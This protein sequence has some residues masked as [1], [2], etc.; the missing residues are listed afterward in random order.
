M[1]PGNNVVQCR[2]CNALELKRKAVEL[3]WYYVK[4]N[5][6]Q[7]GFCALSIDEPIPVRVVGV[8]RAPVYLVNH[9]STANPK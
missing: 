2:H 9:I 7:C 4:R 8:T 6:W 3:G 1:R 5:A